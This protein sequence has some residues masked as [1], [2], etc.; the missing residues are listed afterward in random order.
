MDFILAKY[1]NACDAMQRHHEVD[2]D[3]RSCVQMAAIKGHPSDW[4]GPSQAAILYMQMIDMGRCRE[5]RP[6]APAK[7]PAMPC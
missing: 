1:A 6:P 4:A 3:W 5:R 7:R 2:G